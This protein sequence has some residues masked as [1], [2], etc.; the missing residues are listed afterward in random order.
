MWMPTRQLSILQSMKV[1]FGRLRRWG[2]S[3]STRRMT[4]KLVTSGR[5]DAPQWYTVGTLRQAPPTRSQCENPAQTEPTARSSETAETMPDPSQW[6]RFVIWTTRY[7]PSIRDTV[8]APSVGFRF[9]FGGGAEAAVC[10][11][12][13]RS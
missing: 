10:Q 4:P 7:P 6:R 12:F 13:L 5:N 1:A 9:A 11:P 8:A 2:D 3:M